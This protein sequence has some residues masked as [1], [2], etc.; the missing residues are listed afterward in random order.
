MSGAHASHDVHGPRPGRGTDSRGRAG[1]RPAGQPGP[2]GRQL[3]PHPPGAPIFLV[4]AARSG[5][6]LLYKVMA[7]HPEAAWLSNW[8]QRFP[9]APQLAALNRVA[10]GLPARRT[11]V[12]FGRDGDNAYVYGTRRRLRDR[13]FPMPAE[14][15]TF[16]DSCGLPQELDPTLPT[17]RPD[18]RRLRRG[19]EAISRWDGGRSVLTKRIANNR[20][21]PLLA[22][23]FPD[24]RF[25][26]IVRDGRAV[27]A[28]LA[29]VDWWETSRVWWYGGTPSQ[30]RAAGR[31]P[32][33]LCAR[34]WVEEVRVVRQGLTQVSPDRVLSLAYEE[35][36]R[37][38][39]RVIEQALRFS[40][41]DPAAP[42]WRRSLRQVHFPNQ[43]ERWRDQISPS[44]RELIESVQGSELRR[45]GYQ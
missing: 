36:V 24:A 25:I 7:L 21:I 23:A 12:W 40:N 39:A 28:S 45:Y 20:R 22:E 41:L 33:E 19:I 3:R 30:W 27:A 32:W 4:G 31:D 8:V 18:T 14:A 10:R 26:E 1:A 17:H 5:T 34:N 42:G 16:Y 35:L 29:A 43:N 38:P 15:E 37:D 9:D 44:A 13:L 2:P 11:K 6:S